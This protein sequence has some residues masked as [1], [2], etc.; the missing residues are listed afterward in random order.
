M[1]GF[2]LR[3]QECRPLPYG[4]VPYIPIIISVIHL[5]IHPK[6]IFHKCL[7]CGGV[8]H[9]EGGAVVYRAVYIAALQGMAKKVYIRS[10][11]EGKYRQC[12]YLLQRQVGMDIIQ[13][14]FT[15]C[16]E[17]RQESVIWS[18][19]RLV[20]NGEKDETNGLKP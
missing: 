9:I 14:I 20:A 10:K 12:G 17:Y 15:F 18:Q 6:Y 3:K 11:V 16:F 7:K 8:Q 13:T 5:Y 2:Y 1:R 19:T 4:V